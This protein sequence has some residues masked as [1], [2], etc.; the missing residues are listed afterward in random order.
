MAGRKNPKVQEALKLVDAGM[1]P[2]A[3][4]KAADAV[5]ASVYAAVKRRMPAVMVQTDAGGK[6]PEATL[7]AMALAGEVEEVGLIIGRLFLL[8]E[9][10]RQNDHK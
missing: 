6:G 4:A 5:Q 3:A 9:E 7:R 8:L 10:L 1:N 2:Y